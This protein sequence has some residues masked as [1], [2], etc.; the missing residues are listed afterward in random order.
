MADFRGFGRP[1]R[2]PILRGVL[3]LAG[4][5]IAGAGGKI[6]WRL[7]HLQV[8]FDNGLTVPVTITVAGVS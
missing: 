6:A 2:R 5:A 1:R 7:T 8:F 4:L 3:L